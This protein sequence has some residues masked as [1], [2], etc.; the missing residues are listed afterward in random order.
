MQCKDN[1]N[2][3]IAGAGAAGLSLLRHL[4]QSELKDRRIL[5]A[6]MSFDPANNKTW[7]FWEETPLMMDIISHRWSGLEILSDGKSLAGPFTGDYFCIRSEHYRRKILDEARKMDCITFLETGIT[8]F[9]A[10]ESR[11][12][13]HS[14]NGIYSAEWV[15][16]SVMQSANRPPSTRESSEDSPDEF[17]EGPSGESSV[18]QHFKGWEISANADL[19]NPDRATLMDFDSGY[20]KGLAFYYVLPFSSR[21]ALIEYTVFSDYVCGEDTYDTAIQN[22]LDD[23]FNLRDGDYTVLRRELGEI[24][25]EDRK[26]PGYYN[27][28]TINIGTVGGLAKPS[29]GYAFTRIQRHSRQIVDALTCNKPPEPYS[30]SGYRFRV[31]DTMLLYLLRNDIENSRKIFRI[32]FTKNRIDRIFRFLGERTNFLQELIIFS[33]MPWVPFLKSIFKMRRRILGLV[34]TD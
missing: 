26:M 10:D 29:T 25:M 8:G 24:A 17:S 34:K 31:Y 11:G 30:G 33:K 14:E 16:Q 15:F 18:I 2:Y 19:F 7:C 22:Y 9:S 12:Y 5:L 20:S 27:G 28:R 6:D 21:N 3:I 23:R 32:L 4:M 1:F 13:M